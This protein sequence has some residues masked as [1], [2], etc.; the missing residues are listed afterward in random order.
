MSNGA[1]S[2]SSFYTSETRGFEGVTTLFAMIKFSPA[3]IKTKKVAE[4]MWYLCSEKVEVF[5]FDKLR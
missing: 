5:L 3:S 1:F 2:S 4:T